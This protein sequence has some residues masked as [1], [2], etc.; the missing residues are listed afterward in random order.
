MSFSSIHHQHRER[1]GNATSNNGTARAPT[2]PTYEPALFPLNEVA[3][4]KLSTI[5]QG[6]NIKNVQ[7]HLEHASAKL[8]EAAGEVTEH[9]TDSK[10][11]LERTLE[12]RRGADADDHENDAGED[13]EDRQKLAEAEDRVQAVTAKLEERARKTI[14]G[15]YLIEELRDAVSE[16]AGEEINDAAAADDAAADSGNGSGD[17]HENEQGEKVKK[18]TGPKQVSNPAS[19]KFD[20]KMASRQA[21]WNGLS[22]VQ[23]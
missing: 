1:T 16:L 3:R 18:E 22:L 6:S 14:D 19:K 2:I 5:L 12:R 4:H 7:T 13:D 17:D 15:T 8:S 20:E 9:L 23:R 11:R 21:R 10:V